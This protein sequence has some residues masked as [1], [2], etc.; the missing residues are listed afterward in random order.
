MRIAALSSLLALGVLSTTAHADRAKPLVASHQLAALVDPSQAP[1][2]T[3]TK[4]EIGLTAT[5]HLV[6]PAAAH[7]DGA[8]TAPAPAQRLARYLTTGDVT[9]VV[10]SRSS[11]IERCYITALG[12]SRHG[13]RLDLMFIIARDGHVVSLDSAASGLPTVAAHRLHKCLRT[14]VES[15]QFPARR[16]DTTAIVPYYFQRTDAPNAGPQLSCWNP[17]GC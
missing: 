1:A 12:A 7:S 16:N 17:K 5:T 11:E 4:G 10:A 14:A 13:G 15:L 6:R 8:A 2:P 3:L 9:D